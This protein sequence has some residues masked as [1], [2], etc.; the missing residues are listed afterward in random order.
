MAASDDILVTPGSGGGQKTVAADDIG[1]KL[2]QRVMEATLTF[3][4]SNGTPITTATNTDAVA[5]PGAGKYLQVWRLH[6]SNKSATPVVVSW[7]DGASGALLFET[8][9]PQ[10]GVISMKLNGDW[11]LTANTKLVIN[12]DAAGSVYWTVGYVTPDV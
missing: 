9:L 2:H 1:G 8:N 6:A 4:S 11:D 7:R 10:N 5:A 12:T 3:A